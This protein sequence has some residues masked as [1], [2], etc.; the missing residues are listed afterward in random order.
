MYRSILADNTDA[1]E[2]QATAVYAGGFTGMRPGLVDTP[3]LIGKFPASGVFWE[4]PTVP[5]KWYAG[6]LMHGTDFRVS[7]GG[8]IHGFR[9]AHALAPFK[10]RGMP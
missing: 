3:G 8:F 6:C 2:G 10:L 4:D 7:A 1:P 9:C 5:K